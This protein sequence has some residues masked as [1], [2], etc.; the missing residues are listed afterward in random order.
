[1]GHVPSHGNVLNRKKFIMIY[2]PQ[3]NSGV[4][5]N[6]PTWNIIWRS[7]FVCMK[8]ISRFSENLQNVDLR[9]REEIM[10]HGFWKIPARNDPKGTSCPWIDLV[11][12]VEKTALENSSVSVRSSTFRL[13]FHRLMQKRP[14]NR[15]IPPNLSAATSFNSANEMAVNEYQV[16]SIRV[17]W[18]S[19]CACRN[20][21]DDCMTV[22]MVYL[23][24]YPI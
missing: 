23:A 20:T 4:V 13:T 18:L 7:P 21:L 24:R 19:D 1:M 8:N 6:C 10:D 14:R 3:I 17:C 5:R 11:C 9:A 15:S 2:F 12:K 16:M 22:W